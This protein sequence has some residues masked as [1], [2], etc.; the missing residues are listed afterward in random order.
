M[1]R[2]TGK[3]NPVLRVLTYVWVVALIVALV[4]FLV[5]VV[6]HPSGP[7]APGQIAL[8]VFTVIVVL[9]SIALGIVRIRFDRRNAAKPDQR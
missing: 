1:S 8:T 9:L 4:L 7:F 5:P 2:S 3:R 6:R